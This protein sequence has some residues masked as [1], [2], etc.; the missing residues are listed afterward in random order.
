[1]GL[2]AKFLEFLTNL[3]QTTVNIL[4]RKLKFA[5]F[6]IDNYKTEPLNFVTK[7]FTIENAK[8]GQNQL[9]FVNCH[10]PAVYLV[11]ILHL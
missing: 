8:N 7:W 5:L 9:Y 6:V 10:M 1:M 11:K 2:L 3:F 4:A